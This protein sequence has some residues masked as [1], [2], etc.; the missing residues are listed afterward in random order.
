MYLYNEF[1]INILNDKNNIQ[2]L[3][4]QLVKRDPQQQEFGISQQVLCFL[5]S[6]LVLHTPFADRNRLSDAKTTFYVTNGT[7]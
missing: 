1:I 5:T 3:T 6:K 2:I 4:K 7:K